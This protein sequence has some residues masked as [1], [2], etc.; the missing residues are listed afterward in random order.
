MS[1]AKIQQPAP[2]FQGQAV[3]PNGLFEEISLTTYTA[4]KKWLLLCFIPMAWTFVCPTEIVAFSDAASQF[5][6]RNT[7]V[8]FASADSEYSLLAW[9]NTSRKDGGLGEVSIPL[10][11]DKNHRLSRDYGVLLEDEGIALRGMFLID[12]QGI[13]RQITVNDLAVGRSVEEA[14]RLVDAYQF[15]EKYGEVCPAGWQKGQEGMKASKDGYTNFITTK[16]DVQ[17]NGSHLESTGPH[18]K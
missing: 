9:R 8:V 5:A 12:S 6:S 15:T 4:Q 1:K 14:L 11:S 3:M 2:H 7:Q 17:M 18:V 13:L 10:L 16:N